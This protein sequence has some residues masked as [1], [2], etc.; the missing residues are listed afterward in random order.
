MTDI[1]YIR[2][3]SV[4]QNTDRQIA[5]LKADKTFTDKC[6][7]GS[8]DRPALT[9]LRDY[10]REGDTVHVHSIDRLARNLQ[11]LL[12]LVESFKAKGVALK[13]H[14]ENMTFKAGNSD[15]MQELMLSVM[16]SVAQFEKA[17]IN[18]RQR[19]G[20][21]KA[22]AK[23]VYS[24][25]RRKQVDAATVLNLLADGRSHSAIAT[26]LNCSTKTVQRIKRESEASATS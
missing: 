2:V 12:S 9:A 1:A 4:D 19:E 5:E 11:D 21:A 10:M 25:S 24:K 17:M 8:T 23:G 16:G 22:K 7:G 26:E 13:F 18:E 14:K 15:P 20:I 6:S 3:S